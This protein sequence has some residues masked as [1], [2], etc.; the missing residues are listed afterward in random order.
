MN[1]IYI[2][3]LFGLFHTCITA[4]SRLYVHNTASGANTGTSWTNAFIDLQSALT[5]AQEG[6]TVWVAAGTYRPTTTLERTISFEPRSGVVLLGGFNGT[7][8][9]VTERDWTANTTTLSGDIGVE[10]DSLDNCY[11]VM[12]LFEPDSTTVIDGFVIRDGNANFGGSTTVTNRKRNGG[13]IYMM[14]RDAEAYALVQ[15]C[16]FI[17]N[18]ARNGGGLYINGFG[19][20]SVAPTVKNCVFEY[21]RATDNGGGV[22]R[23]G[24]SWVERPDFVNCIFKHNQAGQDGGGLAFYDAERTDIFDT[25][26][27]VFYQNSAIRFT[28]GCYI[29]TDRSSG[30]KIKILSSEFEENYAGSS[31]SYAVALSMASFTNL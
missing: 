31:S 9:N 2:I 1:K 10:N 23:L 20:G 21:N 19:L 29:N 6:D 7:E 26:K 16:Q 22:M 25:E 4:Q 18:T 5:V 12:Y 8:Q 11:N 15:N 27:C 28:G 24:S 3:I 17:K 13:G 14:G 30:S